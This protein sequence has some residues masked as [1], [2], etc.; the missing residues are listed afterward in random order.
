M[1]NVLEA[2]VTGD[3]SAV[4]NAILTSPA[5]IADGLLN[6][7]CG[8]DLGPLATPG[9][10]VKA[11][12]LL[13]SAGLVFNDDGS[14]YV[15]T[16]GPLYSLQHVLQKIANAIA[17]P[18][19]TAPVPLAVT[20]VAAIPAAAVATIGLAAAPPADSAST[21]PTPAIEAAPPLPSTGTKSG[22]VATT[23]PSEASAEA[24]SLQV[25][26]TPATNAGATTEPTKAATTAPSQIKPHTGIDVTTGNKAEPGTASGSGA[27]TSDDAATP[28]KTTGS[29][30]P[31]P[32][33]PTVSTGKG[34]IEDHS[35]PGSPKDS[36]ER[37]DTEPKSSA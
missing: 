36:A 12:G 23:A 18:T 24:T 15:N 33:A 28:T 19:P 20:D 10:V 11:G 21:A 30:A 4:A 34:A 8:P 6:G 3:L 16:G 35:G 22:A 7:G 5:T 25:T 14:F 26:K 9:L 27:T 37:S 2:T 1:Q 31:T 17:P 13:S 29:P 32:G